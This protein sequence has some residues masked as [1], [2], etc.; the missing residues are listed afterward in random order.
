L[1]CQQG[2]PLQAVVETLHQHLWAVAVDGQPAGALLAA[3]EQA[4]AVGALLVQLGEQWLA[5]VKGG[6]QRLVERGHA[7]RLGKRRAAVYQESA[8]S[9]TGHAMARGDGRDGSPSG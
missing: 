8:S 2:A 6:A 4:V 5:S 9:L 3:M 7:R 1:Q